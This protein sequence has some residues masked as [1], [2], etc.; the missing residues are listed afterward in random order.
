MDTHYISALVAPEIPVAAEVSARPIS[1]LHKFCNTKWSMLRHI[2]TSQ[3][4]TFRFA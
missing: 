4:P 3:K 1:S 2:A